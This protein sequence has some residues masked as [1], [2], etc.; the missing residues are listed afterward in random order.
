MNGAI[1]ERAA[2]IFA[3]LSH[4]TRLRILELLLGGERTV[5]E[6]AAS[7]GLQQSLASQ[8]LAVLTRAG[9][10]TFTP[11]GSARAYR[12]RG[13]RIALILELIEA[14]CNMHHLR[15]EDDVIIDPDTESGATP[16]CAEEHLDADVC[17]REV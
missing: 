6:V 4:P 5:N 7:L 2:V 1:R 8:H 13:P 16:G 12:V 10:L 15:G 3:A 9:I 11:R 14:F 17:M